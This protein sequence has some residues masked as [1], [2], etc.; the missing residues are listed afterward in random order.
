MENDNFVE[1]YSDNFNGK[2]IFSFVYSLFGTTFDNYYFLIFTS[3]NNA[4]HEAEDGA[5]VVIN[6]FAFTNFGLN[7]FENNQITFIKFG[8]R[9]ISG[10]L[11]EEVKV[12]VVLYLKRSTDNDGGIY[13]QYNIRFFNYSLNKIGNDLNNYETIL[14]H[15]EKI[16]EKVG[17]YANCIYLKNKIGLFIYFHSGNLIFQCFEF[18]LD[19]GDYKKKDV[20]YQ[21]FDSD[22]GF[23]SSIMINDVHKINDNRIAFITSK[24]SGTTLVI[25][26]LDFNGSYDKKNLEF[27]IIIYFP[28]INYTKNYQCILIRENFWHF[29]QLLSL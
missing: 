20:F 13:A 18:Y 25:I 22:K 6:K 23:D 1:R 17:L 16:K 12:L 26:L 24:S 27:I 29:L 5:L 15:D 14:K 4:D 7:S 11:M 21:Q 19:N 9:V 3:P 8:D 10:F 28:I 2:R